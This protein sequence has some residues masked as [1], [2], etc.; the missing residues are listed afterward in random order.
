[1]G[2]VRGFHP[3]KLQPSELRTELAV[4]WLVPPRTNDPKTVDFLC[5]I[6]RGS[7]IRSS[8]ASRHSSMRV[9]VVGSGAREHAIA[10][11]VAKS[12]RTP[13]L[14]CFGSASNPAI[15]QLCAPGGYESGKITDPATVVT[16]AKKLNA[17]LAVIGPEAPLETGVADALRAAGVPC[18]G[19]SA[20]LA[21]IECSKG[22][23]LELLQRHGVAGIPKF[24][25][26]TSMSGAREY[27]EEL[28][29]GNYVVKADGLCGG[30]GVMVRPTTQLERGRHPAD[31]ACPTGSSS[32]ES[33]SSP[34]RWPAI[35][36]HRS[37]RRWPTVRSAFPSLFSA[38]SCRRTTLPQCAPN[39]HSPGPSTPCSFSRS[40]PTHAL[41]S[42]SN[43]SHHAG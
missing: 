19:P 10:K 30:K 33:H 22:F 1:M 34:C 32:T 9:L 31:S 35:T 36:W 26:F 15:K 5:V 24:R 4:G 43:L 28:G 13:E 40:P 37:M 20:V 2:L 39:P 38:R 7:S 27:L 17:G 11:A 18:V 29:E 21:Q 23:A 41:L 12:P 16:F 6:G 42:A 25:E 3:S 14:L 8:P